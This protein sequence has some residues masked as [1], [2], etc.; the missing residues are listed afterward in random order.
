MT[1][2]ALTTFGKDVLCQNFSVFTTQHISFGAFYPGAVGGTVKLSAKGDR[3]FTGDIIPIQMGYAYYPA[4]FEIEAPAGTIISI[5]SSPDVVLQGSNGG[6]MLLK[7]G[8]SLPRTPFSTVV[9]PPGR[10]QLWLG[11][12]L[13]VNGSENNKPG[14]Y[15]GNVAIIFNQ[16]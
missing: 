8:E 5:M 14:V 2:I 10:T 16:E 13:Q 4:S 11:G 6:S 9:P 1:V 3:T 12:T 15:S 7:L